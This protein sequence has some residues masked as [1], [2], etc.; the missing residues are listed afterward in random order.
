MV[1]NNKVLTVSYGT[2]SCTLEGFEDS[3]DTMKAIAEYFRDLAA[4]D[5]YFGAEPPQPDADMLARIAQR[6]ISR[7]VEAHTDSKGIVLRAAEAAP[8]AAPAAAEVVEAQP[9]PAPVVEPEAAPVEAAPVAEA[10]PEE[11]PAVVDESPADAPA[12][13]AV[14]EAEE[15]VAEEVSAEEPAEEPLAEEAPFEAPVADIIA[16]EPVAEVADD[17]VEDAAAEEIDEQRAEEPVADIQPEADDQQD[18]AE[19]EAAADVAPI[20]AEVEEAPEVE[21]AEVAEDIADEDVADEDVAEDVADT[22]DDTDEDAAL[23]AIAARVADPEDEVPVV[24]AEPVEKDDTVPAADSIAAKLQRIRAVVSRN[25]KAAQTETYAEDEHAEDV[26]TAAASGLNA[27]LQADDDAKAEEEE[28]DVSAI[29]G[30]LD[31]EDKAEADGAAQ[32]DA[33]FSDLD[34]DADDA[35]D[36]LDNILSSD[37]P[38]EKPAQPKARVL[39]V[40]RRDLEAAI[41]AGDLE[42]A[43]DDS[44]T[45]DAELDAA[46]E[47]AASGSSLLPEDEADLMRE[48]AAVE[49]ELNAQSKDDEDELPSMEAAPEEVAQDATEAQDAE[50]DDGDDSTEE[51]ASAPEDAEPQND[52]PKLEADD[53]DLSRLMATADEKL[54]DPDTS[55]SRE[56]YTHLRAAVAAA[57]AERSAGGTVGTHTSDDDYR[58]DLASVVRPRRPTAKASSPRPRASGERPAPLKLVAEQRIDVPSESQNRGPVRPR[59]VASVVADETVGEAGKSFAEYAAENG[60]VTLPDL[61]E[62]AAAYMSFVEGREQFSRPQLMNKVRQLDNQSFNR[63]DGLR[64]FGQLLR[65]GKIEKAGGGRFVASGDIGFHPNKRAAG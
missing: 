47:D 61:L 35:E 31:A 24:E 37:E 40:K 34:V 1:Q 9:E 49:A 60:A 50:F 43:E 8:V 52:A 7:Q 10:E 25:E 64:S 14:E 18:D 56:A 5:R 44:E 48:L 36:E 32:E 39:K 58:E 21:T 63:E 55:S 54:D 15:V 11:A 17:P 4:D 27:A 42:A 53:D 51:L 6:E 57:H 26:V 22:A 45:E 65:D 3:F 13:E 19:P 12:A 62:A 23:A 28:D 29:L 33:L 16:Q 2:F 59:R 41:A 20:I 38:A 46:Q 30:K